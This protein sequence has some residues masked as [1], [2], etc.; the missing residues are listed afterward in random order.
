MQADH[1]DDLAVNDGDQD[2]ITISALVQKFTNRFEAAVR[3]L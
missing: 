1:P 3:Q 2:V